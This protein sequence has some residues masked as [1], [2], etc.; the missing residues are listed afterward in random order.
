MEKQAPHRKP[1]VGL[2]PGTRGLHPE[3]KVDAQPLSHP[4]VLIFPLPL[5]FTGHILVWVENAYY[6]IVLA[7]NSFN[8]GKEKRIEKGWGKEGERG[9]YSCP[10][11]KQW[12]LTNFESI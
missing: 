8:K 7:V 10:L 12:P 1:D 4:S 6:K 5:M 3:P 2:N 9:R 11:S